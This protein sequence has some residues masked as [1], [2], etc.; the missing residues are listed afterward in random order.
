MFPGGV[1]AAEQTLR[2]PE[3]WKQLLTTGRSVEVST[4]PG[5]SSVFFAVKGDANRKLPDFE[6][7]PALQFPAFDD[8]QVLFWR[9]RDPKAR[10][11][12]HPGILVV[13]PA[14]EAIWINLGSKARWEV[15]VSENVSGASFGGNPDKTFVISGSSVLLTAGEKPWLYRIAPSWDDPL[16]KKLDGN[17]PGLQ[18]ARVSAVPVDSSSPMPK[19]GVLPTWK[20]GKVLYPAISAEKAAQGGAPAAEVP[21]YVGPLGAIIDPRD[22]TRDSVSS[23]RVFGKYLTEDLQIK[24]SLE[25]DVSG[26]KSIGGAVR[27]EDVGFYPASIL[28]DFEWH[29]V[30]AQYEGSPTGQPPEVI[31]HVL[32]GLMVGYDLGTFVPEM[33]ENQIALHAGP[34]LSIVSVPVETDFEPKGFVGIRLQP[35]VIRFGALWYGNLQAASRADG[36]LSHAAAGYMNCRYAQ[37]CVS[38]EVYRRNIEIESG[39]NE[40][41][42]VESGVAVGIGKNL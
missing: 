32:G 41:R 14:G 4:D 40:T 17:F 35:Q 22:P 31:K 9:F 13:V 2:M 16:I 15:F 20:V 37:I 42:L 12:Q 7:D 6:Q 5:F 38:G 33:A 18:V 26:A 8:D 19:S 24:R 25:F 27:I 29:G 30:Q 1:L 10:L 11:R 34:Q 21:E 23:V 3:I 28:A 39:T 36:S